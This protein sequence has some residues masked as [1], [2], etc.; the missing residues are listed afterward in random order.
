MTDGFIFFIN[1]RVKTV[2]KEVLGEC[3]T[4]ITPVIVVDISQSGQNSKVVARSDL[5]RIAFDEF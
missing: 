4:W 1:E 3:E 2:H 5:L